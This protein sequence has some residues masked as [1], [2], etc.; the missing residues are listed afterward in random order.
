MD[1]VA[2]GRGRQDSAWPSSCSAER[3][4]AGAG[5]PA[6]PR[7]LRPGARRSAGPAALPG[8]D[9]RRGGLCRTGWTSRWTS[10]RTRR[11][12]E[13]A[14]FGAAMIEEV[15]EYAHG[16]AIIRRR[17]RR[18]RRSSAGSARPSELLR[19]RRE[20]SPLVLAVRHRRPPAAHGRRRGDRA[21]RSRRRRIAGSSFVPRVARPSSRP[22]A[23]LAARWSPAPNVEAAREL[24]GH[25]RRRWASRSIRPPPAARLSGWP[26]SSPDYELALIDPGDR[27]ARRS[28]RCC[29]SFAATTARRRCASG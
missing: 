4:L 14:Q 17:P 8:H 10:R 7:C 2:L 21:A 16:H 12:A 6:G 26:L 19:Q 28:T 20:P 25:A 15:L 3:R 1:A 18:P 5:R 24:A 22:P 13:A 11:P 27:P 9:A 23:A 29:S